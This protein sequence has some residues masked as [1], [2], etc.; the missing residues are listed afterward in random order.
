MAAAFAV[1]EALWLR[2]LLDDFHI[3]HGTTV[4]LAD[5]QSA[6]KILKN[7]ISSMRSKHIDVAHHFARER[8]A[9][10]DVCFEY[11]HTENMIAD[12]MTKP[13]STSKHTFC[14]AGIGVD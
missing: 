9:R 7:P 11:V 4:I 14:C 6:I 8:V 12:I 2:K 10:K 1:K 3:D 5:N 13:V